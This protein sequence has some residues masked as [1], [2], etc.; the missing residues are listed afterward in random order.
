MKKIILIILAVLIF[1]G[2]GYAQKIE[3]TEREL[4]IQLNEK[5]TYINESVSRIE[6][7]L[8]TTTNKANILEGRVTVTEQSLLSICD[9][10]KGLTESWSWIVRLFATVIVGIFL[11]GIYDFRKANHKNN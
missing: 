6:N 8:V 1:S 2:I 7:N 4:L 3:L 9:R 11:K 10:I 5:V